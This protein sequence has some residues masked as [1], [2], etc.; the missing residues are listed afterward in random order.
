MESG[1]SNLQ[2]VVI[3]VEMDMREDTRMSAYNDSL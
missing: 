2:I 1:S 3:R